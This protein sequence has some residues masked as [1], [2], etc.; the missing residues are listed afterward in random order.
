MRKKK[1]E[2]KNIH[3][4]ALELISKFL[5]IFRWLD[6]LRWG[7]VFVQHNKTD[8]R[9]TKEST[10]QSFLGRPV[11]SIV[12]ISFYARIFFFFVNEKQAYKKRQRFF[13]A[14]DDKLRNLSLLRHVFAKKSLY[15][16]GIRVKNFEFFSKKKK[17]FN[18][19]KK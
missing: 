19:Q 4:F 13:K 6:L 16:L 2:G 18:C 14:K 7:F 9:P 3:F 15:Q 12:E 11:D 17:T 1:S 8:K 5:R 10:V